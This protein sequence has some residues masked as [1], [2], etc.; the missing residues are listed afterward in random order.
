MRNPL[1]A[2][3]HF[4]TPLFPTFTHGPFRGV[5]RAVRIYRED[6]RLAGTLASPG[7]DNVTLPVILSKAK[8]LHRLRIYPRVALDPSLRSG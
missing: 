5:Q 1:I 8:D 6:E 3:V 4:R 7:D 2:D